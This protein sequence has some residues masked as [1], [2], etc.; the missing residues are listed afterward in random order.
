MRNC[1]ANAVVERIQDSGLLRRNRDATWTVK[2]STAGR[3][4]VQ[5]IQEMLCAIDLAQANWFFQSISNQC[6]SNIFFSAR[7]YRGRYK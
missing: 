6:A 1:N 4:T 3:C 2:I 7:I 5:I